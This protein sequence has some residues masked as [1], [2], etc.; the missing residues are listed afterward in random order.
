MAKPPPS[1]W[2][3]TWSDL[4][5]PGI[6]TIMVPIERQAALMLINHQ[7]WC[8]PC[9]KICFKFGA[10]HVIPDNMGQIYMVS[11]RGFPVL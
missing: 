4:I 2:D 5:I 6:T 3:I 9:K 7:Q 11:F 1:R 10:S 8:E